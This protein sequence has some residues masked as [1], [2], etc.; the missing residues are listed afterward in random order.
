MLYKA[1]A[2]AMAYD[3]GSANEAIDTLHYDETQKYEYNKLNDPSLKPKYICIPDQNGIYPTRIECNE[4]AHPNDITDKWTRKY[5][6]Y[7]MK[8][9]NLK[10][11]K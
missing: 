1:K 11:N 9:L 7:K 10:L 6:K 4:Y 3:A 8:Y 5:L 2:A